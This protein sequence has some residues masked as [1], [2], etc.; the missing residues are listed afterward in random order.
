MKPN[1]IRPIAIC[2]CRHEG[3]ILAAESEDP[4]KP[5][6]FYR[7]LGGAI[8]FGEYSAEAVVREF[9]EELG[10]VLTDVRYL[11]TLE[12]VFTYNGQHGHE[13]ALVYDGRFADPSLYD[14][15]V[16]EGAEDNG[17]PFRAVWLSLAECAAPGAP[18][19]YPT[20]LLELLGAK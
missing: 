2:V 4:V 6:R 3:R 5:Q 16:I 20:G 12:N 1:A 8:E 7:P 9:R 11:G 14:R 17:A 13:I 19:V 15:P 18:P 10:V